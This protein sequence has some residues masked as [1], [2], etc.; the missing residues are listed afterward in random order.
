MF[1][2]PIGAEFEGRLYF[3]P[4]IYRALELNCILNS[5]EEVMGPKMVQIFENWK[6]NLY[7]IFWQDMNPD[8]RILTIEVRLLIDVCS[9]CRAYS[10]PGIPCK[11]SM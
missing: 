7:S 10:P 3:K 2:W 6:Q 8:S 11:E 9:I 4:E 5:V 1:F